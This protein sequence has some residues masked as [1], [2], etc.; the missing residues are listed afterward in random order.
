MRAAALTF[1]LFL[2]LSSAQAPTDVLDFVDGFVEGLEKNANSPDQCAS[3]THVM[4]KDAQSI[5]AD[6][7]AALN[8]DNSVWTQ[9]LQDA[10]KMSSDID[11]F[12]GAC[13]FTDLISDLSALTTATGIVDLIWKFVDNEKAIMSDVNVL[14]T[15]SADFVDCGKAAGNMFSVLVGYTI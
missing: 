11:S 12:N 7:E 2:A 14:K 15:C 5:V 9:L 4:I 3:D 13:D 8:G 10:L 1:V 6:V